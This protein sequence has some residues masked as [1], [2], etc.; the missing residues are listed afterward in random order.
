ME[1]DLY[2]AL[3]V[4]PQTRWM[5][6]DGHTISVLHDTWIIDIPLSRWSTFVSAEVSNLMK[7]C[8]LFLA[9]GTG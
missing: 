6:E 5:I 3:D 7:V 2:M 1:R 4:I 8:D 9:D